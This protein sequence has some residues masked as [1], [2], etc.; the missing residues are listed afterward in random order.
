MSIVNRQ[1]PES[2]CKHCGVRIVLSNHGWEHQADNSLEA[3]RNAYV[4][5]H[6]TQAEKK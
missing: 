4:W 5:C 3:W 6:I 2:V 1:C